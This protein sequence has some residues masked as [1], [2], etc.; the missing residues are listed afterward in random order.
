MVVAWFSKSSSRRSGYI[1]L[2][3]AE[4]GTPDTRQPG[5]QMLVSGSEPTGT[6]IGVGPAAIAAPFSGELGKGRGPFVA[7]LLQV[8]VLRRP[9]GAEGLQP[10]DGEGAEAPVRVGDRDRKGD[11][12]TGRHMVLMRFGRVGIDKNS[13]LPEASAHAE[14]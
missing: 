5:V 13:R 11:V 3:P 14:G 8:C 6:S 4:P 9:E 12:R 2:A 10:K 1:R 7:D